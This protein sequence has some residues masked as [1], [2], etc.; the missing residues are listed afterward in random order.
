MTDASTD[1]SMIFNN[2]QPPDR[3][4]YLDCNATT[5]V[6]PRVADE[7]YRYMVEEYGNPGSRT[8]DYGSRAKKAVEI[9]RAQVAAA[10]DADPGEVIF[11]SG[12][13]E[14]NNIVLLGLAAHGERTGK[15]HIVSTQIEHK[16]ILDPL[17]HLEKRGFQITLVP[18]TPGGWVEPDAIADVVR[19]DTLLVSVMHVNNETGV[20]QPIAK[21]ADCLANHEAYFHTDAAQ[22]FG[23]DIEQLC[24]PRIDL[25]SVSGHKV[26]APKGIGALISRRG[27]RI[28]P[29]IEPLTFGGGQ[30]H[31]YRPGTLPSHLVVGLGMAAE[32]AS[33]EH[34]TRQEL[35]LRFRNNL[36]ATLAPLKPE[37]NGDSEWLLPTTVNL[38]FPSLDSEAVI[39]ALR[40]IV[41]ISN[42]SACTSTSYAPSHV[43]VAMGQKPDDA[44]R[45]T[46]WSWCYLTPD[47][48]L[49]LIVERLL[50]LQ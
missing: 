30:E 46:R 25:I 12:A 8:H 35:T 13:T 15:K 28:R 1:S 22:G 26:F 41:S 2:I 10:V 50:L 37:I 21:I 32:L 49:D 20:I 5:P 18:P 39:I 17:E 31:G 9:A 16:A 43:L 14:S 29:P 3:P 33:A 11:T 48:D 24:H 42:G 19:N 4:V 44:Q 34:T 23:K 6:D 7:V 27:N 38:S 36:I 45:A 40:E 47:L